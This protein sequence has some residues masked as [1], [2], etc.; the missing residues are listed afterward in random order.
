M[1][2]VSI[3]ADVDLGVT[4]RL[5]DLLVA[6]D[7]FPSRMNLH[8]EGLAMTVKLSLPADLSCQQRLLAKMEQ[9]PGVRR[10]DLVRF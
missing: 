10:V 3:E 5:L 6:Q 2:G 8:R 4:S 1:P 9:I 7:S